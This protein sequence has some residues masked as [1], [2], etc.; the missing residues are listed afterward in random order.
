MNAEGK[1]IVEVEGKAG[2]FKLYRSKI[3]ELAPGDVYRFTDR[4]DPLHPMICEGSRR[5]L[6][7][8]F[9]RAMDSASYRKGMF[10]Q[11]PWSL[12]DQFRVG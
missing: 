12:A 9:A 8:V 6:E 5:D 11:D 2:R 1:S 4:K 10:H 7:R 3:E